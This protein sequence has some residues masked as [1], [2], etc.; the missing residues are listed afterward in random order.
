MS[1]LGCKHSEATKQKIRE[2]R[3]RQVFSP[4][5]LEKF[6]QNMIGNK[7]NVG[8]KMHPNTRAALLKANTG[9]NSKNW[10]GN[11]ATY[12]SLH[13]WVERH[14]GKPS[15]CEHC[16]TTEKRMYHWANKSHK[17]KRILSDWIRLCVPCHKR[18]DLDK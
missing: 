12:S 8:R 13:D 9:K 7:K 6:R 1:H 15:K 17:Y 18:Y 4:E 16:G 14:L 2:A 5:T 3:A 10:K 11:K